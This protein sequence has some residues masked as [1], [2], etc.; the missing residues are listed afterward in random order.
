QDQVTRS[1]AGAIL[2]T[3]MQAEIA[4]ANR[5]L[6]STWSCY[7][8]YLRGNAL[9]FQFSPATL[10]DAKE[11]YQQALWLDPDFPP[12]LA[13][14][15]SCYVVQRF[16]YGQDLGESEQAKALQLSGRAAELAPD[17]GMVLSLCA[18]TVTFLSDDLEKAII[19]AERAVSLNPNIS[20]AW[21]VLG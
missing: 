17:D 3:L 8:R 15:S 2:P 1:V 19:L 20:M 9:L 18:L 13:M 14:L 4:L 5:K 10:D 12:A 21:A 11:E 6:P 7:D 16:L